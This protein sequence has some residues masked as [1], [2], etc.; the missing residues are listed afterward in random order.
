[1]VRPALIIALLL[2]GAAMLLP[3]LAAAQDAAPPG[4]A[5]NRM[6]AFEAPPGA[7]ANAAATGA[8]F[9]GRDLRRYPSGAVLLDGELYGLR[10]FVHPPRSETRYPVCEG[11]RFQ[12]QWSGARC[13]VVLLAPDVVATD[14]QCVDG[15]APDDLFVVFDLGLER[16]GALSLGRA[17]GAVFRGVEIRTAGVGASEGDW[18]LLRL[19][20]PTDRA[21]AS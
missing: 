3:G 7:E 19:D 18:A 17:P 21:P 4:P 1:M 6:E 20:R 15:H 13:S 11:E 16:G 10:Q 14:R 12:D 2:T 5:D 8:L 9:Y